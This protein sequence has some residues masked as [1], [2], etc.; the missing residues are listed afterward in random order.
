MI[1]RFESFAF[2]FDF[3]PFVDEVELFRLSRMPISFSV[4]G[5]IR[6]EH[7]SREGQNVDFQNVYKPEHWNYFINGQ[8]IEIDQ[9]LHC[10]KYAFKGQIIKIQLIKTLHQMYTILNVIPDQ[11]SSHRYNKQLQFNFKVKHYFLTSDD[12]TSNC[13]VYGV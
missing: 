3:F 8:E 2:A 1:N 7:F 5:E 9:N 11:L 4:D 13:T 6:I 12:L 10:Q